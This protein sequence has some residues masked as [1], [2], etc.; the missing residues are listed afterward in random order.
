MDPVNTFVKTEHVSRLNAEITIIAAM[1]K[2]A[3][4]LI[5]CAT[6]SNAKVTPCAK[7]KHYPVKSTPMTVPKVNASVSNTHVKSLN[8]EPTNTVMPQLVTSVTLTRNLILETH[9]SKLTASDTLCVKMIPDPNVKKANA[10]VTNSNV[11]QSHAVTILT[12]Q[13]AKSVLVNVVII[14]TSTVL[15]LPTVRNQTPVSKLIAKVMTTVVKRN[16]VT[17]TN[18]FQLNAETK[19]IVVQR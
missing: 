5:K 1:M 10:D 17:H 6:Q 19:V 16:D 2:S 13:M 15:T 12:A 8:A 7:K 3:P 14:Q 11:S 18:V 4:T 9:V